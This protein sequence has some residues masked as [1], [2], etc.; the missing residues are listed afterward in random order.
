MRR[1]PVAVVYLAALVPLG[2][3]VW[4]VL[5]GG[6]G[7]DPVKEIEHRLGKIALWFLALGLAVTPLRRLTG[8][9][10]LRYRR[11]L[12]LSAAFYVGLHILAWG[13]LDMRWLWAQMAGDLLKRPYLVAGMASA[14]M[15]AVLAATSNGVSVRALGARWRVLHRLTYPAAALAVGH[16]LWQMKVITPEGW[17]WAGV[18]T[19]LLALR[20]LPRGW[21]VTRRA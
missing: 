1:L 20:L 11:A 9:N 8:V 14:L 16:Y 18:M 5:S 4:L 19:G 6:I 3:I 21:G 13:W 10:L 7:V 2:W 12:G 15:I 17:A